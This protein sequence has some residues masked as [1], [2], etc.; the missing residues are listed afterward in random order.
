MIQSLHESRL[1]GF[2]LLERFI[3]TFFFILPA[4]MEV[5][6]ALLSILIEKNSSVSQ[7]PVHLWLKFCHNL[8]F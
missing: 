3:R 5:H 4:R 7:M 2:H 8:N 1:T 6:N